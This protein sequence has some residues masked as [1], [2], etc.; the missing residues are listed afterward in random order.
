MLVNWDPHTGSWSSWR[1]TYTHTHEFEQKMNIQI[2]AWLRNY[3]NTRVYICV[4][5]CVCIIIH[6][7]IYM[8]THNHTNMYK[9]TYKHTYITLS[10]PLQLPLPLH[11]SIHTYPWVFP[12]GAAIFSAS[13]HQRV[14]SSLQ[15][16]AQRTAGIGQ[17]E[18]QGILQGNSNWRCLKCCCLSGY[19]TLRVVI[20]RDTTVRKLMDMNW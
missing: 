3:M 9:H 7:Y 18:V 14:R 17:S 16:L 5:A 12:H 10:L 19:G 11:Y 20:W 6:I 15:M 13:Q 4:C 2:N 1:H 8:C